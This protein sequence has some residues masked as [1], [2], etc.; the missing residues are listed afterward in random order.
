MCI[1]YRL[2][3]NVTKKDAYPL[4]RIQDCLDTIGKAQYLSKIDLTSGYYQIE[5]EESSIAKTAFNTRNG[6]YK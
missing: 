4:P 2:L 3:N 6:K 1:D 5:M